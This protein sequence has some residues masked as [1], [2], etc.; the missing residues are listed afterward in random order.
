MAAVPAAPFKVKAVYEYLSDHPD[1]LSFPAS[2]IITVTNQ[3]DSEWFSGRYFDAAGVLHE[4]LFPQN[5]VEIVPDDPTPKAPVHPRPSARTVTYT[6]SVVEPADPVSVNSVD[7]LPDPQPELVPVVTAP[8][9]VTPTVATPVAAVTPVSSSP[10]NANSSPAPRSSFRDRIAAFNTQ[11][12]PPNPQ[13]KVV[14]QS[15]VKKPFV[16]PAPSAYAPPVPGQSAQSKPIE[17]APIERSAEQS[18]AT[19]EE[20][21]H[22]S[23]A[24]EHEPIIT[25]GTSLKDRIALLQQQQLEQQAAAVAA[26]TGGKKKSKAHKKQ[27]SVSSASLAQSEVDADDASRPSVDSQDFAQP[28]RRS[29]ESYR[30][31]DDDAEEI[32]LYRRASMDSTVSVPPPIPSGLSE[33]FIPES[34]QEI[35]DSPP[36]VPQYNNMATDPLDPQSTPESIV[37][38]IVDQPTGEESVEQLTA[39]EDDDEKDGEE[40]EE[41]IDPEVARRMAIRERMAKMSG[42]MGMPFA[43]PGVGIPM[44][45]PIGMPASY[46][47]SKVATKREPEPEP[48]IE[49]AAPVPM[50]PMFAPQPVPA[51]ANEVAHDDRNEEEEEDEENEEV[52]GED[53]DDQM[54]DEREVE[55]PPEQAQFSPVP[56]ASTAPPVPSIPL[57]PSTSSVSPESTTGPDKDIIQRTRSIK[58]SDARTSSDSVDAS[59]SSPIRR[60]STS[61]KL[62]AYPDEGSQSVSTGQNEPIADD[63]SDL[64][65][66]LTPSTS[67]QRHKSIATA[68]LKSSSPPP[69]PSVPRA[70]T[71]PPPVPESPPTPASRQVTVSHPST[72]GGPPPVPSMAPISYAPP[73]V[74]AGPPAA[75]SPVSSGQ[76]SVPTTLPMSSTDDYNEGDDQ[77]DYDQDEYT[78]DDAGY[79]DSPQ[80]QAQASSRLPPPP[81]PPHAAP[82]AGTSRSYL[83]PPPPPPVHSAQA[84]SYAPPPSVPASTH[85]SYGGLSTTPAV[86]SPGRGSYESAD[87]RSADYQR[88]SVDIRPVLDMTYLAKDLDITENQWWANG[89]E[90]VPSSLQRQMQA[91]EVYYEVDEQVH[92]RG[93]KGLI[94]RTI[95]VLYPDYSQTE[96]QVTFSREHPSRSTIS[97]QLHIPPP[98]LLRRDALESEYNRFGR[99]VAQVAGELAGRGGIPSSGPGQNESAVSSGF[100]RACIDRG[101][102]GLALPAVGILSYGATVYSNVG[103]TM[104]NAYDEIRIGDVIRFHGAKFQGHKGSLHQKYSVEVGKNGEHV[105]GV[106]TEWDGAKKKIRAFFQIPSNPNTGKPSGVKSESFRFGDLKSGEVVVYRVVGRE[107]VNWNY[108]L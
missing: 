86:T 12:A 46:N 96:L 80:G 72:P 8:A 83:P 56:A 73:P 63:D 22:S 93:G 100:V 57:I 4:G 67:L 55:I 102:D 71:L 18:T 106:V 61:S 36:A 51:E 29:T 64:A 5:F 104:V 39:P 44:G 62:S 50:I 54:D 38:Q 2:Q 9:A 7:A 10:V 75:L 87:R 74:F 95:Y 78:G 89:S 27:A 65:Q 101:S 20:P 16:A 32:S 1:D 108:E 68:D 107:F 21:T 43:M 3:E 28:S 35:E 42:G 14:P 40:E 19:L 77:E 98:G 76:S 85:P 17:H 105:A 15:F 45:L 53:S 60:S 84:P 33:Q 31:V 92:S 47:R 70:Y 91:G 30:T 49:Q 6:E 69:S 81:L 41:E 13:N 90:S 37:S 66:S 97:G 23:V 26:K 34:E 58:I 48:E 24:G 79:Y 52:E 94:R 103:N 82:S 88:R 11:A 99:R 59:L 25:G